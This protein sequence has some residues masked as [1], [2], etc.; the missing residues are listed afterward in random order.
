MKL[1]TGFFHI[2]NSEN[3][4]RVIS[5]YMDFGDFLEQI[6]KVSEQRFVRIRTLSQ[7]YTVPV[8]LDKFRIEDLTP[9]PA[10]EDIPIPTEDSRRC[11][12]KMNAQGWQH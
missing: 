8:Q 9:A 12:T 5:G 6:G 10:P 4:R 3:E 11:L 7:A 2:F 1:T